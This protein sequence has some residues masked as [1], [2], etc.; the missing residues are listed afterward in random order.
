MRRQRTYGEL[1]SSARPAQG[2]V[3]N[4]RPYDWVSPSRDRLASAMLWAVTE[5]NAGRLD[6]RVWNAMIRGDLGRLMGSG[7]VR[8]VARQ[9]AEDCR[10]REGGA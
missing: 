5:E 8:V 6:G 7:T 2:L 1:D 10:A 4:T 9:C 3:A